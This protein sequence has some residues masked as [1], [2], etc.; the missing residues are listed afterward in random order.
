MALPLRYHWLNLLTRRL[1]TLLTVL[2]IAAVTGLFCWMMGFLGALRTSLSV[3]G[4]DRTLIVLNTG[5]TAEGNSSI[6]PEQFNKLTQLSAVAVDPKTGEPW[7]SPEMVAQ[8]SLPRVRDHGATFANVAVRGLTDRGFQVHQNVRVLG[9]TFSSGSREVIVGEAAARQ[10]GGLNIGDTVSLGHGGDRGY[11]IVGYFSA[12]GGPA[13]SE[14]WGSLS[15]LMNSYHRETYSS[16]SLRLND[17]S[18]P[19]EVVEEIAGPTIQL[20]ARTEPDYWRGQSTLIGAYLVLAGGLVAIMSLA[21]VF[22]IANTMYSSVAGRTREI[23]MLRTI[24]FSGRQ[25]LRGFL[26]ESVMFSLIGGVVGMLGCLA[27]LTLVGNTKDMFGASTFTT[28]AFEIH[29]DWRIGIGALILVTVVGAVGALL[30][31]RR[32]ARLGVIAALR[33]P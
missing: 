28:L 11:E 18:Q 14:I 9:Q 27:W 16:A 13:E 25:I 20:T 17:R 24:G 33:E 26:I 30:P 15:S 31:A 12:G 4:N 10:F 7:I 2:V 3:A 23:A 22:A 21:A 5:A 8:V 32:A 29:L 19:E 1:T 6:R